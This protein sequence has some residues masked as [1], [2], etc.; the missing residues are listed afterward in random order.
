MGKINGSCLCGLVKYSC[1]SAPVFVAA[2]HCSAC[3]KATGSAFAVV[4]GLKKDD[5]QVLGDDLKIYEHVGDSGNISYRRFCSKCG[6]GIYS[7]SPVMRPGMVTVRAGTLDET[8][9]L[10]PTVNVYWRDRQ[11]WIEHINDLPQQ[12]T[13]KR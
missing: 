3:Q 9:D 1:T 13:M 5:F 7:E 4:V 8:F 12:E 11:K 6:S 2:C 10:K